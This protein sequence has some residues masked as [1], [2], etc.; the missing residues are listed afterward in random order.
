MISFS[1]VMKRNEFPP[2]PL[3]QAITR[4]NVIHF[5]AKYTVIVPQNDTIRLGVISDI[6]YVLL[7]FKYSSKL[8][9][10]DISKDK[11][12][13]S[14]IVSL[15]LMLFKINDIRGF[16]LSELIRIFTRTLDWVGAGLTVNTEGCI[17]TVGDCVG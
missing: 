14:K 4:L 8:V 15:S 1:D 6:S 17:D 13:V 2:V 16:R 7:T 9:A 10:V 11:R 12:G 5:D 3:Y